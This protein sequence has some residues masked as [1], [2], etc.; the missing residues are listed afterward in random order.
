[1]TAREK[2]S[3]LV[4]GGRGFVGRP[5]VKLIQRSGFSVV[6]LDQSPIAEAVDE[7]RKE[8]QCDLSDEEQL[9]NLFERQRIRR[10]VHLAAI[11]PTAAQRNPTRATE[12]NV[13]GSLNLLELARE[14]DVRRFV[15]GSSLSIYGTYSA[16]QTVSEADRAAPEDLYGAAK[17]YV[18]QLGQAYRESHDLEFVSLRI[19]RV[20]GAGAQSVS[21]AWRSE[22]FELLK[23]N[24]PAE[25]SLPYRGAENLLVLHVEDLAAML[26]CLLRASSVAHAV[27]NAPCRSVVVGDLK[28]V[29]ED[30]NSNVIVKL[31]DGTPT[32]N[33][34]VLD[35]SRFQAEFHFES[36]SV[37][38]RLRKAAGK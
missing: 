13:Q 8:I 36:V 4:T 2:N 35:A 3:I 17:L 21:S 22:I 20:I 34:Q 29:I 37:F 26:L 33:P 32:G 24:Y 31:G 23:A 9:R 30:L 10:I 5:L 38:D 15:F 12:V 16:D 19:G 18:E 1:M 11:L 14:F 6:S 25:I 7:G 28:R 27:Y